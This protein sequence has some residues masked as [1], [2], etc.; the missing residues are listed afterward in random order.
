MHRVLTPHRRTE[1]LAVESVALDGKGANR[2]ATLW[3][4]Y[5]PGAR[6][7]RYPDRRCA[8]VINTAALRRSRCPNP[9]C[10]S[11]SGGSRRAKSREDRVFLLARGLAECETTAALSA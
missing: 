2:I 1:A 11:R 5:D 9:E 8:R 7:W 3:T 4:S 10:G 6:R